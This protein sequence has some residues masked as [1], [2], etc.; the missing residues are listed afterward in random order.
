M[1]LFRRKD[2]KVWWMSFCHNGQQYKRST[3]TTDKKLAEKIYSKVTT[4]IVED[5]WFEVNEAS[6]H[7]F[8]ELM[9]KFMKIHAP[10]QKESTQ[11]RYISATSHL[12]KYFSDMTLNQ[13]TPKIITA[14]MQHRLDQGVTPA[15]VNREF[16]TLSKAMKLAYR[17]W[18]WIRENPCIKVSALR[19]NNTITRYLTED[20]EPRLLNA[21]RGYLND[22]M[23]DIIKIALNTGLRQSEI[24]KLKWSHI[25]LARKVLT[26]EETKNNEPRTIPLN[27]TAYETLLKIKKSSVVSIAGYVFS[28]N[29]GT[30]IL[31]RNL[32][33]EFYKVLKK[34]G[35]ENLRFHDLRHTFATR[36]VQA[37][38]DL[39]TVAKLM[40]HRD[41][42]STQRYAHH[43]PETLRRFVMILDRHTTPQ[44]G[45]TTG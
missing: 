37:G 22:Q 7:T 34:A 6:R 26:V 23:V 17:E 42:E 11:K 43:N 36:L 9:E 1:G 27:L 38:V 5:R 31:R 41:L 15:T 40:G 20:E 16:R 30:A 29:S 39:Y 10:R 3:Y 14:Y 33:R 8:N 13:I 21:A 18:E 44:I 45:Q 28:T 25:D 4:M 12:T 35:I 2:S 19:E 32:M 24:L